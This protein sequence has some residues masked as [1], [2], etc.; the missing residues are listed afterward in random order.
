MQPAS[1][2]ACDE[3]DVVVTPVPDVDYDDDDDFMPAATASSADRQRVP[4]VL[5]AYADRLSAKQSSALRKTQSLA[6]ALAILVAA[7]SA[8]AKSDW[9][10][11]NKAQ[12]KGIGLVYNAYRTALLTE[13]Q[14]DALYFK[15]MSG[16]T[17]RDDSCLIAA[18]PL[19]RQP[20]ADAD[21]ESKGTSRPRGV[22]L[23]SKKRTGLFYQDKTTFELVHLILMKAGRFPP[24]SEHEV[25]HLCHNPHCI[26]LNHLV[27]EL[28]PANVD[29]D[30]CR[31]TRQIECPNC[32]HSFG[33]CKHVPPCVACS[34]NAQPQ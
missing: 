10:P 21:G 28:H 20:T 31:Y 29:R 25:S 14:L 7:Q 15:A 3:P 11:R 26:A 6:E 5:R 8:P 2:T 27:W 13:D 22:Q 24:T 30:T 1:T 19:K 9:Q 18:T 17:Q 34:C 12:H 32:A 33:L 23:E 16:V 4:P